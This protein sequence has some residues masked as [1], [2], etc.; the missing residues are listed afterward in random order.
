MAA[1]STASSGRTVATKRTSRRA[2]RVTRDDETARKF[3]RAVNMTARQIR[4][5]MG[6]PES[7]LAS[8]GTTHRELALLAKMRETPK[9]RW[10]PAMWTKARRTVAFVSRHRAQL[11]SDSGPS[12]KRRVALA[13][14]GHWAF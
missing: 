1:G 3:D 2:T 6:Q 11:R 14:W 7:R 12:I 13:N 10:T 5:W 8:Y 4:D 9:S